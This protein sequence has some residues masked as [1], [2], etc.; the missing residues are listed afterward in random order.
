MWNR[1]CFIIPVITGA[2][3]IVNKGLDV[4]INNTRKAFNRFS[5]ANSCT[6]DITH[7]KES[8]TV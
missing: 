4:S 1:K 3:E 5:A 2:K 7:N 8:D 6:R